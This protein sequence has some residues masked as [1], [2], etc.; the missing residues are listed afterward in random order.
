MRAVL[1]NSLVRVVSFGLESS[2]IINVL[3][4]MGW[5]STAAAMVIIGTGAVNELLLTQVSELSI[6]DQIVGL[7][8]SYGGESPATAT[9]GLILN[10]GHTTNIS[11]VPVGRDI[12]K[13]VVLFGLIAG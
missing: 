11:P 13:F 5:K 1:I 2:N 10:R 9:F 3:E 7:K 12:L 8:G 4:G 6:L